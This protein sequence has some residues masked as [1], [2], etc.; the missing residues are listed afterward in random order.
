MNDEELGKTDMN[1]KNVWKIHS[2]VF[3]GVAVLAFLAETGV[4]A[5]DSFGL[6]LP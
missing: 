2:L 3:S 4:F 5:A 6:F 1:K